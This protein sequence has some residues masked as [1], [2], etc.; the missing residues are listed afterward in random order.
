MTRPPRRAFLRWVNVCSAAG[1]LVPF[2]YALAGPS[3]AEDLNDFDT[4]WWELRR[5]WGELDRCG[6]KA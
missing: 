5:Q 1:L 4:R 3:P 2:G 6:T